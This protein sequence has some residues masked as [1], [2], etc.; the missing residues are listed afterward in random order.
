VILVTG[1]GGLSGSIVIHEFVRQGV[2]VRALIRNGARARG[3]DRLASVEVVEGD[4][5]RPSTLRAALDGVRRAL[6]I[7]S[8]DER[9]VETQCT[10]VDAARAAGVGHIVKF[11]GAESGIGFD[12]A[13]FRFTR[14]HEEIERYLDGSGPAWTHLRPSQFM[15]VYLREVRT[16]VAEDAFFLP[17]ADASLSP[18]DLADVAKVAVTILRDGGH[19][20]RGYDM[21]GPEAL[22]GT[23]V[24]EHL[25]AAAGRPIRYVDVTP[26]QARRAWLAAGMPPERADA[27]GELFS[28][29]RGHP[30]SRVY[31]GTHEAFAVRPT[32]FREFAHRN[33]AAFRGEPAH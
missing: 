9:M 30:E 18:V 15:Q 32:T 6:M 28:E 12:P 8:S 14:M 29:R 13:N 26:E 22:T 27:L 25:S 10:F 3:L 21:T 16:I 33:A 20:S 31:L 19:E 23:Q 4:M 5:L 7:S 17:M 2:P 11:S 24:A 1:A